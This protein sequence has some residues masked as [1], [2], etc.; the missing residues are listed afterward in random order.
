[1]DHV[2]A[3]NWRQHLLNVHNHLKKSNPG[4]TLK[5]SMEHAR[6]PWREMKSRLYDARK[7]LVHNVRVKKHKSIT[8]LQKDTEYADKIEHRNAAELLTL[9]KHDNIKSKLHFH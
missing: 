2:P 3:D 5:Q 1:M 8:E 4:V 9:F 7:T 6:G